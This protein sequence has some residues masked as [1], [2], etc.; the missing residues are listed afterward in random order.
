M[1]E[2]LGVIFNSNNFNKYKNIFSHSAVFSQP[3]W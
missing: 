2:V 3:F 1:F